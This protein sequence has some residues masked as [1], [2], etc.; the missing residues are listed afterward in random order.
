MGGAAI[1]RHWRHL[2][3]ENF[4]FFLP[5]E[6]RM[7]F[8]EALVLLTT[9]GASAV[10]HLGARR[11]GADEASPQEAKPIDYVE[12]TLS[13]LKRSFLLHNWR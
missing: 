6:F 5:L 12:I 8:V 13:F 7:K 3:R 9:L 10:P 11:S 4:I 1:G 2:W